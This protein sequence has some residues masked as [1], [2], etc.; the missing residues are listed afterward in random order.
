MI[1][2]YIKKIKR[3]FSWNF[4]THAE[5]NINCKNCSSYYRNSGC[6]LEIV[7]KKKVSL[8]SDRLFN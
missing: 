2:K 1:F 5:K 3:T 7:K 4:A 8:H 6:E